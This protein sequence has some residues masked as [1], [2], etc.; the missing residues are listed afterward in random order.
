M[1]FTAGSIDQNPVYYEFMLDA[2]YRT[3]RVANITDHVIVRS[4]RRYG[5]TEYND[6]VAQAWSMLVAS[7]YAQDLSV[8]DSSGVP[9]F[10]GGASQFNSDRRTPTA[11]LCTIYNAWGKMIDAA[12]AVDPKLETFRYDLVNTGR[13]LLAQLATPVS[14]NFSDAVGR[15]PLNAAELKV[16]GNLYVELLDDV[17]TLVGADQA[18][19]VGPWIEMARYA[20]LL[21]PAG[22]CPPAAALRLSRQLR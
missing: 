17:D 11:T 7:A 3:E 19:L 18:F 16:T 5:L 21:P 9:H 6:D 14:M 15:S 8:Q 10:P 22:R 20:R 13:E 12:S 4:H 2:N 1:G